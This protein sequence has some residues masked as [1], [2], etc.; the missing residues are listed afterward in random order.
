MRFSPAGEHLIRGNPKGRGHDPAARVATLGSHPRV[1]EKPT[2][3]RSKQLVTW[4]WCR[5]V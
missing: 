4:R 2:R 5:S 3:A 1:R